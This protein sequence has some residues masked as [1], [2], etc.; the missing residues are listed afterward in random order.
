MLMLLVFPRNNSVAGHLESALG[1]VEWPCLTEVFWTL[2]FCL[3]KKQTTANLRIV[4]VKDNKLQPLPPAT[5]RRP[6]FQ[7]V[8]RLA[9]LDESADGALR[10]HANLLIK[11]K[12]LT[13]KLTVHT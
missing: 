4:V 9:P 8:L 12:C 7:S 5:D 6:R 11:K 3:P 10:D 2:W 13:A 1:T